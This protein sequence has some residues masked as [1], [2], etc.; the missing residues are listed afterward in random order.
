MNA[1]QYACCPSCA[2]VRFVEAPPCGEGH[3]ADCPDRACTGCGT[4]L[5]LDPPLPHKQQRHKPLGT[6]ARRA[7]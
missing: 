6:A 3:G 1:E 2:D 4:A 5:V 7:A